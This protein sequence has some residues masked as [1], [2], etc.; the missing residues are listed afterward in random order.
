MSAYLQTNILII[1]EEDKEKFAEIKSA[2]QLQKPRM[3]IPT[4]W[5]VAEDQR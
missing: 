2:Q 3:G 4:T 1:R 5:A